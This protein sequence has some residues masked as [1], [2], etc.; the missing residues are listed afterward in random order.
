MIARLVTYLALALAGEIW[1][2]G[3]LAV[4][5]LRRG[6]TVAG[7]L[8][9]TD[10]VA[11]ADYLRTLYGADGGD[12]PG[13]LAVFSLP[14]RETRTVAGDELFGETPDM[15]AGMA[16]LGD[17]YLGVCLL[18]A[19]PSS[20][21]GK[22]EDT[23]ATPGQWLDLDVRGPNHSQH[24]LPTRDEAIGFIQSLGVEPTQ[25]IESGGGFQVHWCYETLQVFASET[26]RRNA[27]VLNARVQAGIIAKGA[28]HGWRLDNTSDLARILRPAGTLNWKTGKPV[29][30]KTIYRSDA[31]YRPRDFVQLCM[32]K[33]APPPVRVLTTPS[34]N[35]ADDSRRIRAYLAKVGCRGEGDRDN[36]CR[37]VAVWLGNDF[38]LSDDEVLAYL[39]EWNA[40]NTPPLPDHVLRDK[41]RRARVGAKRQ[42]GCAKSVA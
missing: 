33:P 5:A 7:G 42:L 2:G 12:A 3:I 9:M 32:R 40:M 31:R 11:V 6:P 30:V 29:P 24:D 10:R 34:G 25:V 23:V 21:R 15:I 19:P 17:V 27:E 14:K 28:E 20:G 4:V 22:A 35:T 26:D 8:G 36:T 39:R 38:G 41:A 1:R 16:A 18:K 13:Y 37:R